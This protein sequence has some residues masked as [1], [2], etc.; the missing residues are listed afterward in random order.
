[1]AETLHVLVYGSMDAGVC[2]FVRLGVYRD[3]LARHDVEI[4][5]WGD[6]NDYRVQIPADYAD[7]LDDAIRDGVATIDLAPIEWADVLVFRRWYGTIV[8]CEECDFVA[9]DAA[10]LD[11]HCQATGHQPIHRDRII[12][13]LLAEIERNRAVLRGRAVVYEIDDDLLSTEPWVGFY[14]RLQGDMDLVQRLARL[15]DLVTVT[16]PTLAGKMLHINSAVRVIRN[17]VAPEWYEAPSADP[18]PL[19][20]LY[21][22]V[23]S[24]LHDYAICRD[25][26]DITASATGAPRIW[27]GS[28]VPEVR[29]VVDQAL[30]YEASVRGFINRLVETRPAIGLAPVGHDPYSR[31]RS[32]LH[33][34]EYSLAGAATVASRIMGGGPFDVIRDGVDGL[35]ARNKAEWREQLRKLAGSPTLRED[36]AG[37]A[38]ERVL[39]EYDV[40]DR[41]VEWADAFRWAAEHAGRGALRGPVRTLADAGLESNE[42]AVES[43]ARANLAHRQMARR[44]AATERE[45]LERLR[46]DR[47]VCWSEEAAD[48]PIVSIVIPADNRSPM[49]VERSI[50]SALAQTY[51][52]IELIV[53]GGHASPGALA[54]MR[55]I[56][57]TRVRFEDVPVPS[58]SPE[59]PE[60]ARMCAEARSLNRALEIAR[61]AWIV[62]QADGGDLEPDHIETL[63][64]VALQHRLE[65]VYGDSLI[66][67]PDAGWVRQGEWPPRQGGLGAASVLHAAALKFVTMDEECWRD[68]EP[69]HWNRLRRMLDAGVRAGHMDRVVTR[70]PAETQLVES[71]RCE[72]RG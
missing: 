9:L 23:A 64:S 24:R 53:V 5:T 61:G 45:T 55:S 43:E 33:W 69:V 7:R 34:L 66:E 42:S 11:R 44:R 20:F 60:W 13:P 14:G 6:F 58:R 67:M 39:A 27:L 4:R 59:D 47:D 15:A 12:R 25:A 68:G 26:V 38:R 72:R 56:R 22:G 17:A 62:T 31:S 8:G 41:A 50:A 40:R 46:G 35:L 3:L 49:L 30:P 37:R 70:R 10:R 63:L 52:N 51:R 48:N 32:E 65:L 21:Y 28:D 1:M 29:A 71:G 2:D 57:D 18:R 36:L 19:S 54:A 16:T